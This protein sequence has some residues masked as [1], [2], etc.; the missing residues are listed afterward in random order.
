MPRD[1]DAFTAR[2][3]TDAQLESIAKQAQ[4]PPAEFRREATL[5][6]FS[7]CPHTLQRM[8]EVENDHGVWGMMICTNC[9]TQV[10]MEC[11]HVHCTWYEGGKVLVCSNCGIDG[12]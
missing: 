7:D 8:V 4:V 9:G 2:E 3:L 1:R 12:T 11:P 6:D 10:A 5:F